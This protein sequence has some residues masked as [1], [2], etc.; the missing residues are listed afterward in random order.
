MSQPDNPSPQPP[1]HVTAEQARLEVERLRAE[2]RELQRLMDTL[3]GSMAD[4]VALIDSDRRFVYVNQAVRSIFEAPP[5]FNIGGLK[6]E[7][8]L[9]AWDKAGDQVVVDGK[10]MSI[11]ERLARAFNPNGSRFER[12]LPSGRYV[13]ASFQPV[14]DGRTM[15]LF[16]DITDLKRRQRELEQ[17]RDQVAAAHKLLESVLNALPIGVSVFDH[18]RYLVYTNRLPGMPIGM[19]PGEGGTQ[20]LRIDDVLRMLLTADQRMIA[21]SGKDQALDESMTLSFEQRLERALDPKGSRF[22]R[23]SPSGHYLEY[24]W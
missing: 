8:L 18:D 16:R 7:D 2:N 9:R 5:G 17:A 11:D 19:S 10:V 12:Q 3:L 15:G 4:G 20:R 23:R 1:E 21:L 24:T 14:G 13:E 22:E 6:L